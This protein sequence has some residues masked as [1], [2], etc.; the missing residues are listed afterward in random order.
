MQAHASSRAGRWPGGALDRP[1][2]RL[3]LF[4]LARRRAHSQQ[5][6]AA[7]DGLDD[8]AWPAHVAQLPADPADVHVGAAPGVGVGGAAERTRDRSRDEPARRAA[9]PAG[10]AAR[11]RRR[12]APVSSRPTV[13]T[14]RR[15]SRRSGPERDLRGSCSHRAC[16]TSISRAIEPRRCAS[17]SARPAPG[18]RLPR[19]PA[20]DPRR[21][22]VEDEQDRH[23]GVVGE[24]GSMPEPAPR[25]R[26]RR[27]GRVERHGRRRLARRPA[28]RRIGLEAGGAD[29]RRS[30]SRR[31]G[32]GDD[33]RSGSI[34]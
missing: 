16:E 11:T 6:A 22:R 20:A 2:G 30:G 18:S 3:L 19:A 34:D 32:R 29:S 17:T 13:A 5:V 27:K 4:G 10:A 23:A 25:T 21:R 15:G 28:S 26:P 12:S 24:A 31:R 1:L 14:A 33:R 9:K 7:V 8:R